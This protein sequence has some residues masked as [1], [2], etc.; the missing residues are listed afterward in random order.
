MHFKPISKLIVH[1]VAS[2]IVWLK[3]LPLSKSGVGLSNTKVLGTT[4]PW[5]WRWLQEYFPP[6]SR[7]ICSGTPILWTPQHNRYWWKVRIDYPKTP[8]K[9]PGM[10]FLKPSNNKTP[11]DITLY[12]CQNNRVFNLM[13]WHIQHQMMS[14]QNIFLAISMINPSHPTIITSLMITMS[15]T[16]EIIFL[17]LQFTMPYKTTK[18][19]KIQSCQM[20][21]TSLTGKLLMM[22]TAVAS[23]IDPPPPPQLNY[24]HR[25]SG[26]LNRKK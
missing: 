1:L 14:R 2:T 17:T 9:P 3:Y 25:R 5:D 24:V 11:P 20:M 7:Q 10:I 22:M 15:M 6:T 12:P 26:Q 18:D 13:L 19:W 23:Y 21:K 8:M 4:F 16:I